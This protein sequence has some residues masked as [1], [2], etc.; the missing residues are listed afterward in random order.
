MMQFSKSAR[1]YKIQIKIEIILKGEMI[2]YTNNKKLELI[3]YFVVTF[4]SNG[5]QLL[6]HVGTKQSIIGQIDLIYN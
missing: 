1:I 4:I 5:T 2:I 6:I 3:F